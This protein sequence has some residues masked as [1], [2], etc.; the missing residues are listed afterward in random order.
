MPELPEVRAHAERL[1]DEFVGRT[2]AKFEPITF[3]ALKTATPPVTTALGRPLTSISSRGKFLLLTLDGDATFVVHLMQGG[4]LVPDTRLSAR[5]RGGL[6]RWRFDAGPALLLTEAGT[7]RKAG[8]WLISGEPRSQPPLEGLGP[9]ADAVGRD[10]LASVL[11]S[12]S[13]RLHGVL[14]D[15]HVVAG[16]GRRLA[17]EVCHTAKLS[18][19]AAA[20]RLTVDQLDALH[21]AIG[22]EIRRSLDFERGQQ[23]M[24][25][26]AKR[27]A[28]VHH[29]T[30]EACPVCGDTIR[31]VEYRSYTV[32]Y[33]ATCQTGGKVLADNTTSKFLR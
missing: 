18:P 16:I 17:N 27:P 15:Q 5:P 10:E 1:A 9:E 33:C 31:A 21:A 12:S 30:G 2:L 8:T 26:S 4:R 13:G 23:E 25:P 28:S 22:T 6:C 7:E 29:R 3:T 24:V 20:N 19:F 32:N 11:S 14:R